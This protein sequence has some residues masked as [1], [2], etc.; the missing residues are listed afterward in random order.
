MASQKTPLPVTTAT[1]DIENGEMMLRSRQQR[2]LEARE[3]QKKA[4]EAVLARFGKKQQLTRRFKYLSSIAF[5][6]SIMLTWEVVLLSIQF[7]LT[8]GGP[9]G[10]I[11]GFFAA[12]FG[13][14]L[15]ALVMAELSSMIP[16]AGGA[17]NWVA[18]L[19]PESNRKFLSYLTGWLTAI[20]W[21]VYMADVVFVC[22]SVL[23]GLIILTHAE[24]VP[25]LWH[26]TLMFYA[27]LA[28]GLFFNGYLGRFLPRV[29]TI[30]LI[31]YII[32]FFGIIIP[33]TYLGKRRT[34]AEVFGTF[35]NLGGWNSM[36][37][38]FFVGWITSTS[39][40]LGVDGADHIAEEIDNAASVIP[41]SIWFSTIF[42]GAF[43]LGIILA[44]LFATQDFAAASTSVTGFPFMD[45]FSSA[46][47]LDIATALII[48][49]SVVNILS[50]NSVL[51]TASRTLWAFAREN[52]LPF[53][54]FLVK[55]QPKTRLPLNAN[56]ASIG[57]NML[58]ALISVGSTAAFQAFFSVAVAAYYSSFFIAACVMLHKRLTTPESELPWGPFRLGKMGFP[59]TIGALIYTFLAVF[60]SFWPAVTPVN[61]VSM[62]YAALIFGGFLI[63]CLA[64]WFIHGRKVYVGPIWELQGE[65]VRTN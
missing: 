58:L 14:I 16:L 30:C 1:V 28:L 31:F 60:F 36:G 42:N 55:V 34:A 64:F 43:G 17:F 57:I 49:I 56:Y 47:G 22:S 38:S 6:M 62:N 25:K 46:L 23:Q 32:G 50:V 59:I 45:I 61:A 8:N 48:V 54:S 19:S 21:Q 40:F 20:S 33:L 5:N 35:Q 7:G 9:G 39:A 11:Y 4:D 41:F 53:S 26:A 44:V 63:I 18:V 27:I 37:L 24:Y 15:Q 29:E 3:T 10:L 51:A 65:Y 13:S 52:G 2:N 12:W